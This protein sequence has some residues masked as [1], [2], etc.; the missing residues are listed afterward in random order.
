MQQLLFRNIC[1]IGQE[2][3]LPSEQ[4]RQNQVKDENKCPLG[5]N[6]SHSTAGI[7]AS[8]VPWWVEGQSAARVTGNKEIKVKNKIK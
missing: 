7:S 1:L 6:T 5:R 8:I 2:Q 3:P 4:M